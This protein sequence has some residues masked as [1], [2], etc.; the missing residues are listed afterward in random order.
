MVIKR[1]KVL[2][3]GISGYYL[4]YYVEKDGQ[5]IEIGRTTWN[6][7]Y[8]VLGITNDYERG[9]LDASKLK[10]LNV[11][12]IKVRKISSDESPSTDLKNYNLVYYFE[13]DDQEVEIGRT[14]WGDVSELLGATNTYAEG[15][16]AGFIF[17]CLKIPRPKVE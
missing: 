8:N 12:R 5:E 6:D 9:L 4:V 17:F 1:R 13:K 15:L 10:G 16:H 3:S 2:A 14:T 7:T 11:V